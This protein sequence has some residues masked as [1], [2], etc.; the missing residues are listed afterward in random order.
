LIVAIAI[1]IGADLGAMA[2]ALKLLIDGPLLTGDLQTAALTEGRRFPA[3]GGARPLRHGFYQARSIDNDLQV[4]ELSSREARAEK[5][6]L[7]SAAGVCLPSFGGRS[8]GLIT[9]DSA[10]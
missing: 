4:E 2:A 7:L 1:N 8:A 5:L 10:V 9:R 3:E 6:G